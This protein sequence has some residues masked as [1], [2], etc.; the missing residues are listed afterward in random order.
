MSVQTLK[1]KVALVTGGGTGL[2]LGGAKRLAEEGAFV[3]I[4]GRRQDVLDEAIKQIGP[5]ARAIVADVSRK[6]DMVNVASV[7]QLEKGHLDIIFSN[8][9]YYIGKKLEDVS[10]E[11]FDNMLNINLKGQ[12]F[13]VQAMLPIMNAG[14]SIIL[15]SSMTAFIGLPEYTT[16][17]ATKAAVIGMA[18]VWTTELKTRNIRV[19]V[20]SPGAIPTEGYETVQGMTPEEVEAFAAKC[21][22][23]IPVGRVGRADEIGD[24]VV[25]L[26]SDASSFINGINLTIDGGQTQVYAGNLS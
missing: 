6:E 5:N 8:A 19:N 4:V 20:I 17:A 10:E 24:G 15:T 18:R 7:I 13:T 3:Y 21:A 11:F 26:A 2:G 9:G 23:E 1:G 12:L 25:F 16:Y 14:G 22:A